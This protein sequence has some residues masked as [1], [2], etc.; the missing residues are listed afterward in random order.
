LNNTFSGGNTFSG[1]NQ[2]GNPANVF[3][4]TTSTQA[5]TD[6][7]SNIASTA[8]VQ[9]CVGTNSL[10]GGNNIWSGSNTFD[11]NL[12]IINPTNPYSGVPTTVLAPSNFSNYQSFNTLSAVNAFPTIISS[13][14][15]IPLNLSSSV[16]SYILN[17][18]VS[19]I[20]N[21]TGDPTSV[22]TANFTMSLN[23]NMALSYPSNV[24][25]IVAPNVTYNYLGQFYSLS[26]TINFS[27]ILL[28]QGP[29]PNFIEYALFGFYY[30]SFSNTSNYYTNIQLLTLANP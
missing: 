18:N 7:S 3:L 17:A 28:S 19:I 29:A 11:N 8:F 10:I 9:S 27:S 12:S 24:S 22:F 2:F 30:S 13:L 6:N 1:A 21:I 23:V 4:G 5:S 26:P 15:S 20:G 16:T 25:V 14:F